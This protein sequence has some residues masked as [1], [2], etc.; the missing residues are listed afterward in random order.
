MMGVDAT[1]VNEF[2]QLDVFVDVDFGDFDDFDVEFVDVWASKC[3][4]GSIRFHEDH[5]SS[6][7][8]F[9]QSCIIL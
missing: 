4:R 2:V 3:E 1:L 7:F 9:N 6:K 8:Y 5:F